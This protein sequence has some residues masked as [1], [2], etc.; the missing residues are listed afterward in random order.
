MLFLTGLFRLTVSSSDRFTLMSE[1]VNSNVLT[2]QND[3]SKFV[4]L[5]LQTCF[6]YYIL[7]FISAQAFDDCALEIKMAT[8][9]TTTRAELCLLT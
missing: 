3:V 9:S 4:H 1:K 5:W 6:S 7:E 2:Q 8:Y